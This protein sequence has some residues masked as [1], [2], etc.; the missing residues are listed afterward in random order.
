MCVRTMSTVL[1]LRVPR[2]RQHQTISRKEERE[3]EHIREKQKIR[4]VHAIGVVRQVY[5][6]GR[7]R[8]I[9]AEGYRGEGH[10]QYGC[11]ALSV[12]MPCIHSVQGFPHSATES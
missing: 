7:V 12:N 11:R 10:A 1:L 5:Y 6:C 8:C 9:L 3:V 2:K 4:I